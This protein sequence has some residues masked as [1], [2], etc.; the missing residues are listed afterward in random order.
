MA[1]HGLSLVGG[2]QGGRGQPA[3]FYHIYGCE[4]GK[5]EGARTV[6]REAPRVPAVPYGP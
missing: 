3:K 4:G 2:V 1:G 6:G 5:R